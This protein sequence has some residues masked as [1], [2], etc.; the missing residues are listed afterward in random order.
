[1]STTESEKKYTQL[2]L[3]KLIKEN[4]KNYN[5]YKLAVRFLKSKGKKSTLYK[6]ISKPQ[7]LDIVDEMFKEYTKEGELFKQLINNYQKPL[8][9]NVI[10]FDFDILS[11]DEDFQNMLLNPEIDIIDKIFECND[12]VKRN[13]YQYKIFKYTREL[14]RDYPNYFNKESKDL[15]QEPVPDKWEDIYENIYMQINDWDVI[16]TNSSTTI[17]EEEHPFVIID[18]N[19]D[20]TVTSCE[21][22]PDTVLYD[23]IQEFAKELNISTTKKELYNALRAIHSYC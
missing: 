5:N 11:P 20:F 19:Y 8:K 13:E 16:D 9:K 4:C 12:M 22:I 17:S 14:L 2:E 18:D 21:F 10:K 1:M 3:C 7:L 23:L 6:M 15:S